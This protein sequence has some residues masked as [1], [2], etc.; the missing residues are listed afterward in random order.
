MSYNAHD[1]ADAGSDGQ[2]GQRLRVGLFAFL[3]PLA[4]IGS[5]VTYV[6]SH[7]RPTGAVNATSMPAAVAE[8]IQKVGT[9]VVRDNAPHVARTG[10]EVFKGSCTACHST[11]ALGSPK[12][13]DTAA[14][15]PRIATGFDALL[16]SALKGKNSMPPQGGGEYDEIEVGR[17]LVYM[18]NAAGAKFVP[19][20]PAAPAAPPT[21]ATSAPAAK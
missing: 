15:A 13:G 5:L 11:G 21:A 10:E 17:A 7:T 14:W 12:F 1:G 2:F 19:P 6:V 3:V 18:A 16:K 9:V 8:R 20:Q 4:V